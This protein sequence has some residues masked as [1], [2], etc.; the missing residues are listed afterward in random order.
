MVKQKLY[1]RTEY[2]PL[3]LMEAFSDG[4]VLVK[5]GYDFEKS[6]VSRKGFN[7]TNA[8]KKALEEQGYKY[9]KMI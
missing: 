1:T 6:E 8:A 4:S 5:Y 2:P 9:D 7:N 3:A